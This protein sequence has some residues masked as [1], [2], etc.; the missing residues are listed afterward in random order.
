M[1]DWGAMIASRV[2]LP[3]GRMA[4]AFQSVDAQ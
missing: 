3:E 2:G 4:E 1:R